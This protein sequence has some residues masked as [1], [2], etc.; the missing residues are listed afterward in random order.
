MRSLTLVVLSLSAL[1]GLAACSSGAASSPTPA[2]PTTAGP[3][4]AVPTS[5][6]LDGRTFLSTS[7]TGHDLVPGSRVTIRFDGG[8]IGA[9]AGCNSMSGSYE[10]VDGVL[11]TGPMMTT[12]MGCAE[13]LMAQDTWLSGFLAGAAVTLDGDILTLA[14]DGVTLALTDKEVAMPDRP[15]EGTRW[16]VDGLVSHDAVSS[17]PTGV[18]ASLVFAD[19]SVAVETGCNTGSGTAAITDTT[20]TFGPIATTR[21]ACPDP[22]MEV[23]ALVTQVLSG[24]V[25]YEIDA[26]TLRLSN[27]GVGLTLRAQ[28]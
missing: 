7:I 15:L 8:S 2:G 3:T 1:M 17:V 21:M 28:P 16:V 14:R 5:A 19:G 18:T 23:E 13:P 26:D 12:E 27:G 11:T 9:S 22:Q 24:E 25:A 20:I 6:G 4:T 10:I